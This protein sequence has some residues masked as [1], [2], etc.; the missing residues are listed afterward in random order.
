M[1]KV[2]NV[3]ISKMAGLIGLYYLEELDGFG[4][5]S[6]S[7]LWDVSKHLFNYS[8]GA[9]N[10]QMKHKTCE[11]AVAVVQNVNT[12]GRARLYFV[13]PRDL[14][15]W[16]TADLVWMVAGQH[17]LAIWGEKMRM[18]DAYILMR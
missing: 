7:P 15:G 8:K 3:K 10:A 6:H 9:L 12:F 16:P 14:R 13:R 18:I 11:L 4:L 5:F 1:N 2:F 17:R